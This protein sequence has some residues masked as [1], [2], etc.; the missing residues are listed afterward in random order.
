MR[1]WW[2]FPKTFHL[3]WWYRINKYTAF[4]AH[5]RGMVLSTDLRNWSI[6]CHFIMWQN[7]S[8]K[9]L[10]LGQSFRCFSLWLRGSIT[11]EMAP[12]SWCVC[13]VDET[14]HHLRA[15]NQRGGK[16]ECLYETI[17][18]D[19]PNNFVQLGFATCYPIHPCTYQWVRKS[20]PSRSNHSMASVETQAES[21]A[22]THGHFCRM[23]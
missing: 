14:A 12:S 9:R 22:L 7:K 5:Q 20:A 6:P 2:N 8:D 17:Q 18:Q 21:P 15:G 4:G 16:C 3:L 1:D 13:M 19:S 11:V 23:L 10:F